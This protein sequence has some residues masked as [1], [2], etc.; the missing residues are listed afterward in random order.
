MKLLLHACCGPCACYP[1]EQ[2]TAAGTDFDILF[3]NPDISSV[4]GVQ[5]QAEHPAGVL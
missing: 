1:T 2:L 4:Q 5:A 3:F